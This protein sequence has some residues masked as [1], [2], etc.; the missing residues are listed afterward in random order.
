MRIYRIY[1]YFDLIT[2]TLSIIKIKDRKELQDIK[3]WAYHF[4]ISHF[5]VL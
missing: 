3:R 1:I 4:Y 2:F 5:H